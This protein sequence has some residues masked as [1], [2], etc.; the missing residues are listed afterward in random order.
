MV[1]PFLPHVLDICSA[2]ATDVNEQLKLS[3]D[4]LKE[5]EEH[6]KALEAGETFEPKLTAKAGK[7]KKSDDDASMKSDSDSDSES[8]SDAELL[9]GATAATSK[10][11]VST[12]ITEHK[13]KLEAKNIVYVISIDNMLIINCYVLVRSL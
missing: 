7:A 1:R 11:S 4:I 12:Q 5:H 2:C 10:A 6:L 3:R 8:E 13:A 9:T